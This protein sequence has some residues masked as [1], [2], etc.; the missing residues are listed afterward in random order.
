MMKNI[1]IVTP[2]YALW[3]PKCAVTLYALNIVKDSLMMTLASR[4][5][6]L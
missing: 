1:N 2:M 4:N 6:S 5:M 3:D